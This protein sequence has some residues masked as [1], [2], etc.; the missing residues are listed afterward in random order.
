VNHLSN[1][2]NFNRLSQSSGERNGGDVRSDCLCYDSESVQL[3]RGIVG[4]VIYSICMELFSR[5]Y[6][7]AGMHS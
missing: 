7:D 4:Q 1:R 5:E 2:D 6:N 3:C